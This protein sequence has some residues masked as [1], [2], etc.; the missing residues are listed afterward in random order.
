MV[1]NG[2]EVHGCHS[3]SRRY[4]ISRDGVTLSVCQPCMS[5]LVGMAG[6]TNGGV[7]G[8]LLHVR[9]AMLPTS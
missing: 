8:P 9:A 7:I 4:L 5:E 3:A 2:C 1:S 6:W